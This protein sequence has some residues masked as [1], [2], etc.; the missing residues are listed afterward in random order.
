MQLG[1]GRPDLTHLVQQNVDQERCAHYSADAD[2]RRLGEQRHREQQQEADHGIEEDPEHD[3]AQEVQ[4]ALIAHVV[5]RLGHALDDQHDDDDE[6]QQPAPL[7]HICPEDAQGPSSSLSCSPIQFW[8]GTSMAW[9]SRGM[10]STSLA[11]LM[12][13]NSSVMTSSV[14]RPL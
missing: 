1:I 7:A 6:Q 12:R 10:A 13:R 3:G 4:V 9:A 5:E 8:K 11:S 2:Q 14:V